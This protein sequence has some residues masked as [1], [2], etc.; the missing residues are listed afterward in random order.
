M[1]KAFITI[2]AYLLILAPG[3]VG[4]IPADRL[5]IF[6]EQNIMFY[7]PDEFFGFSCSSIAPASVHFNAN[8]QKVWD[9][10][11][12]TGG[13]TPI[14]AAGIMGNIQQE[15]S[16]RSDAIEVTTAENKGFGLIQWTGGRRTAIE[17][18]AKNQGRNVTDLIFQLEYMMSESQGRSGRPA[19]VNDDGK[20][21]TSGGHQRLQYAGDDMQS[22]WERQKMQPSVDIATA[23]WHDAS[24]R[25]GSDTDGINRR[26]GYAI[27][28]YNQFSGDTV[29]TEC[30]NGMT[31]EQAEAFMEV[32]RNLPNPLEHGVA[33]TQC[34]GATFNQR[35]LANCVAFSRYFIHD[36]TT[37]NF[38]SPT[39]HGGQFV[40]NL[41]KIGWQ[42]GT[43][44]RPY[45]I[46]SHPTGSEFGHTGVVLGIDGD[47][48][49]TGE[50]GCKMSGDLSVP[51][52]IGVRTY[53][54]ADTSAWTFAY[55]DGML[56][57]L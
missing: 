49:I 32:Y 2:I 20:I 23:Y 43:D 38:A 45:A 36:F 50:A 14:P 13:M 21:V 8:H 25:S 26:I 39:G 35:V 31:K 56:K 6:A 41:G 18:A 47:T 33:S 3:T 28:I 4:A 16:F 53:R 10:L 12:T 55:T 5:D 1:K 27:A 19:N 46:F 29:G 34:A 44:V 22:E 11:I 42:T 15:S 30:S 7:N 51:G 24:E 57:G 17:N 54:K 9:W 37:G 52:F 48:I 40:A